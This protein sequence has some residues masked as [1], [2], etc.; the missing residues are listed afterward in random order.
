MEQ[1]HIMLK[2]TKRCAFAASDAFF[3]QFVTFFLT[4]LQILI[5]RNEIRKSRNSEVKRWPNL[6]CLI[7]KQSGKYRSYSMN[8]VLYQHL[9][10]YYVILLY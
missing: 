8:A 6:L 2:Y 5:V 9:M 3:I 1:F 10:Q 4:F 7:I